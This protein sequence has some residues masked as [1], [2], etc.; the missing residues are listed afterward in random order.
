MVTGQV[1]F[2]RVFDIE[3]KKTHPQ[4]RFG[5][6]FRP[7]MTLEHIAE[8][9][10]A[11][12]YSNTAPRELQICPGD[13]ILHVNGLVDI[14]AKEELQRAASVKIHFARGPRKTELEEL[15]HKISA[16]LEPQFQ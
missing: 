13:R 10:I 9:S 2:Q 12:K 3:L 6:A 14:G 11:A 16:S 1:Y 7:D 15:H 8:N 5:I 4:D